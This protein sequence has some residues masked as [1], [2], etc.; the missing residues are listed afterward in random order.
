MNETKVAIQIP[1][2]EK[3]L[4]SITIQGTTPL[5]TH[6]MSVESLD[7]PGPGPKPVKPPYD[8][9]Q[10]FKNSIYFTDDGRPGF[11]ACGIK[12]ACVSACRFLE[13]KMTEARGAFFIMGDILPINGSEPERHD[14]VV[15]IQGRSAVVRRRAIFN[16]WSITMKI[17]HNPNIININGIASLLEAAGF[18][19][20]I[21]DWR[22]EKDGTMGMFQVQRDDK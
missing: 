1:P 6:R 16:E 17:L 10:E 9:E 5:L 19:I 3:S 11:P 20:G 4:L 15:R 12:K 21:G 7:G 13:M 22:P 2:I 8:L 18:H 14:A